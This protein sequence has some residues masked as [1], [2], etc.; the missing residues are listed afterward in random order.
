MVKLAMPW[1]ELCVG[2]T[3]AAAI[4]NLLPCRAKIVEGRLEKM[5]NQVALVNQ[6]SLSDPNKTVAEMIKETISAVGE[7]VQVRAGGSEWHPA[8]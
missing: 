4:S 2:Q 1:L 3:P 8:C 5:R 6:M 7:N